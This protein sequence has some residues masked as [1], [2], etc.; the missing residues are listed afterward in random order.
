VPLHPGILN[1]LSPLARLQKHFPNLGSRE[2]EHARTPLP[3]A[4]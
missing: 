3:L 4:V 1:S 2:N